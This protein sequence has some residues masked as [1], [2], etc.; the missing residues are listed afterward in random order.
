V[1]V[2]GQFTLGTPGPNIF[3]NNNYQVRDTVSWIKG[4]HEIKFGGEALWLH[5]VQ[6]FIGP[7]GFTFSGQRSGNSVADLLLGAYST[8]NIDFGIRD[9][10]DQNF[11]PS[12]FV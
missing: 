3:F 12:F 10:D 9:N 11:S 5:F 1:G 7:P 4:K 2:G 6:R 8:A